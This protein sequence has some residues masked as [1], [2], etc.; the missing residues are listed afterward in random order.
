MKIRKT[1]LIKALFKKFK[2]YTR[3]K[4]V[5]IFCYDFTKIKIKVFKNFQKAFVNLTFLIYYDFNRKFYIN[6]DV[7]KK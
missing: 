3:K 6:F 5:N 1:K 7:F 4:Q 2:E